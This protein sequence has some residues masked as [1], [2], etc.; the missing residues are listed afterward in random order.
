MTIAP[1]TETPL[2]VVTSP[3]P[4]SIAVTLYRAPDR[5]ARQPI[6]LDNPQGYALVTETRRVTLPR[7]RAVLRFEGVAG[8]IIP[9]SAV[10]E[11]L[12]GGTV[13]KNRDAR[14]LSPAALVDGTL[15]NRV[16]LRRTDRASG[17]VREEEATILSGPTGGVV[18]RTPNGVEALGCVGLADSLK[19]RRIPADLAAKPVL[20]VTTDSPSRRTV[21]VRLSYLATGFDW[22]ASYVATLSGDR[23]DLFAWTTLANGNGE[24][25]A[26][27]EVQVVAGRLNRERVAAVEAAATR[28]QLR[29]YPLG[30]T[31][32]DLR[33]EQFEMADEIV[34]TGAR[35]ERAP[36]PPPP[37]V[38]MAMAPAPPPPPAPENLGDV[39]LYRVPSRTT[40]AA[41]GQKQVALLRQ[42]GVTYT[43]VYRRRIPIAQP[44]DGGPLDIALRVR[45]EKADGLGIP[46]PA[47]TTALYAPR[48]ETALLV[49][50]GTMTDR[51]EG[52]TLLIGA[53]SS[54]QVLVTQT[55]LTGR[56]A[57]L[58]VTNAR[59]VPVDVE[60]PIGYPG[61][62]VEG[63]GLARIDGIPTWRV[64]VAPGDT[65]TLDYRY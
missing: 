8:G 52:E 37:M 36:P 24:G 49:G 18:V 42:D 16:T 38:A 57:R 10:V 35:L 6:D 53:G 20:S 50:T 19:Y 17:I 41:K 62:K 46:L 48:G 14:V 39:K 13:E 22:S 33:N 27:A 60:L 11:G 21:T 25:F 43:R 51:A 29:C 34:V 26:D 30:T 23:L 44:I 56:S 12:P 7:G 47:G 28:L 3:A 4:T 9:V 55:P 59:A 54:G 1:Y 58:T 63:A 32:S 31:T 2:P 61:G 64:T 15:G 65:A 5:P 45:N 40:V